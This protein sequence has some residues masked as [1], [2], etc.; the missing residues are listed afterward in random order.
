[1]VNQDAHANSN[2]NREWDNNNSEGRIRHVLSLW[3]HRPR[4]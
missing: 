3:M 4:V 2:A 1:M